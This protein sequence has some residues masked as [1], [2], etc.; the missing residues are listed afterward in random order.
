MCEK[1]ASSIN[2]AQQTRYNEAIARRD[3]IIE[4]QVELRNRWRGTT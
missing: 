4:F 2:E 3:A 1:L